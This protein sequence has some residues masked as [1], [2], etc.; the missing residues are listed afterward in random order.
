MDICFW[1]IGVSNL[2][3]RAVIYYLDIKVCNSPRCLKLFASECV[4]NLCMFVSA[5]QMMF[6]PCCI[7]LPYF[8]NVSIYFHDI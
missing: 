1:Q 5:M 2:S 8:H 3:F 6:S 4:L 7:V